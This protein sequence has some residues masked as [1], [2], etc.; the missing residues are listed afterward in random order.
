MLRL[1]TRSGT[2]LTFSFANS[3]ARARSCCTTWLS[4]SFSSWS[5]LLTRSAF[6]MR[7]SIINSASTTLAVNGLR[8]VASPFAA[9]SSSASRALACRTYSQPISTTS[10]A[11]EDSGT[12]YVF[13][14]VPDLFLRR[15]AQLDDPL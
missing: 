15:L 5:C 2:E 11:E 7:C 3:F 12:T 1:R 8:G 13:D 9:A 4:S 6:A 10:H 14:H